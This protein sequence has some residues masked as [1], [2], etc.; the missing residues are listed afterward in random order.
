MFVQG[1][2]GCVSQKSH[3]KVKGMFLGQRYVV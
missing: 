2:S 3:D 1:D